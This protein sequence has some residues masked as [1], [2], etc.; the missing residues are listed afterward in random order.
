M[1][2]QKFNRLE[3]YPAIIALLTKSKLLEILGNLDKVIIKDADTHIKVLLNDFEWYFEEDNVSNKR[4][5]F[6]EALQNLRLECEADSNRKI[7]ELSKNYDTG[8]F[9][10]CDRHKMEGCFI[11]AGSSYA[12]S[13]KDLLLNEARQ[14][15]DKYKPY[16]FPVARAVKIRPNT[17]KNKHWLDIPQS[18]LVI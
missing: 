1:Y 9:I 18:Q 13:H 4:E 11:D 12:K 6:D 8:E 10:I 14:L 7:I 3:G 16:L 15:W 5:G 2:Y 17:L